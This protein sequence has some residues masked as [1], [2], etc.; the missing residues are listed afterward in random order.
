MI[1]ICIPIYNFD[2]SDLVKKLE[3]QLRELRHSGEIVLIDD[4]SDEEYKKANEATCSRHHYIQLEKNIGRSRIRN[5]FLDHSK[6]S[7]L[8]FLDCDVKIISDQFLHNYISTIEHDQPSVV[9]GGRLYPDTSPGREKHLRWKYGIRKE[10]KSVTERQRHPNRSFMTNNFLIDRA[11]LDRIR[12]DE[13]LSGYG[14]EDTLFGYRLKQEN[15]SIHHIDNPILNG[16]IENNAE[17]LQKTENGILN[18]VRI[19]KDRGED[20]NFIREVTL[21]RYYSKLKSRNALGM[22]RLLFWLSKPMIRFLLKKG[23]VNLKLFDFYKL[24]LLT[25]YMNRRSRY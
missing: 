5:R 14:H 22:V 19:L 1:S 2:V 24:G 18:L 10:S 13:G 3:E 16:D 23:I 4:A 20:N 17:Y 8:L 6:F 7:H 9:C 25:N 11:L 12:F 21:L 15:V